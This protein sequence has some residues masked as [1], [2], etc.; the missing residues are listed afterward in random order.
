M[1]LAVSCGAGT[2]AA[3]IAE[4]AVRS[5]R[6]TAAALPVTSDA[7]DPM[8]IESVGTCAAGQCAISRWNSAVSIDDNISGPDAAVPAK[9]AAAANSASHTIG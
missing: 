7:E 9:I 6:R 1:R 3:D 5:A 8:N 4:R 2:L